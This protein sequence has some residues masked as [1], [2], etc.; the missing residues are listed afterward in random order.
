MSTIE[1]KI[2]VIN[3]SPIARRIKYEL[4]KM[5]N[6]DICIF[7]NISISRK[8]INYN[9]F[10]YHVSIFND[11]DS[12]QYEFILSSHFPFKPP[13]LILNSKPYC[14][15]LRINSEAFRQLLYKYKGQQCFCCKTKLCGDNWAPNFTISNI[16]DEAN[17]IY[18]DCKEIAD[19]ICI[20]VIKRKYLIDD[21]NIIEWLY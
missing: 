3:I 21:V 20:N 2:Q 9:E 5:I 14:E 6:L 17:Q 16:M 8:P 4:E 18:K 7:D 19:I 10:E 13:K 1:E 15:Y 12:R 11:I